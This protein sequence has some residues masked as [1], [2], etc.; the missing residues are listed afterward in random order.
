MLENY[1]PQ[2]FKHTM[3]MLDVILKYMWW[4][5]KFLKIKLETWNKHISRS[6]SELQFQLLLV[7]FNLLHSQISD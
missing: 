4:G 5:K 2:P 1:T 6:M 7:I 3:K